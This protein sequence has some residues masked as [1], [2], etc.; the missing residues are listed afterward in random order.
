MAADEI[1]AGLA[2]AG[3]ALAHPSYKIAKIAAKLAAKSA[4]NAAKTAGKVA[5][6]ASK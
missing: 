3:K 1:L 5:T 4:A 2:K 6:G